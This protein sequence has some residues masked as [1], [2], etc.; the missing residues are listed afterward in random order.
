MVGEPDAPVPPWR[1]PGGTESVATAPERRPDG[2]EP[3]PA[4]GAFAIGF[5]GPDED[6]HCAVDGPAQVV[7][8]EEH[9]RARREQVPP[10]QPDDGPGRTPDE[11]ARMSRTASRRLAK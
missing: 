7:H 3:G 8:V 5:R 6:V 2:M 9:P 10:A 11:N 4:Q 1:A